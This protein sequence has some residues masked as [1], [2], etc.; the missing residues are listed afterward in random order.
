MREFVRIWIRNIV[1]AFTDKYFLVWFIPLI[2]I[3]GILLALLFRLLNYDYIFKAVHLAAK[4]RNLSDKETL[5]MLLLIFSSA[6][7]CLL[8]IGE[9]IILADQHREHR[10]ASVLNCILMSCLSVAGL[11]S[12]MLLSES[13]CH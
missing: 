6:L 4:C 9:F 3:S 11:V 5:V 7:S 1:D 8:T 12:M 10:H 2:T 13:W